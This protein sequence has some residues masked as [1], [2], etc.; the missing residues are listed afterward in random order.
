M[1][2]GS[3]FLFLT[4][5]LPALAAHGQTTSKTATKTT[6]AQKTGAS[7]KNR[8]S[9]IA[10]KNPRAIIHTTAG[11]MSCELFADK[12]PKAVANFIGLAK[13]TKDWTNPA[14]KTVEHNKP[15]YDGV[16]FHRVIPTFM[17]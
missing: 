1:L 8:A 11:N 13:G 9:A 16:I 7:A 5:S 12:A 15:L 4:L 14:T 3:A 17:I 10:S 6:G 2:R